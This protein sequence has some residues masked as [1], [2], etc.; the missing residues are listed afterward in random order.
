[1]YQVA[2]LIVCAHEWANTAAEEIIMLTIPSSAFLIHTSGQ[3][4][5]AAIIALQRSLA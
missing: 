3:L 2:I 5:V 4:G 1:L